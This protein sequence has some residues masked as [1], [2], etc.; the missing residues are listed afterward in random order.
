[1]TP[2]PVYDAMVDQMDINDNDWVIEVAEGVIITTY[3]LN[4]GTVIATLPGFRGSSINNNNEVVGW[5]DDIRQPGYWSNGTLTTLAAPSE[6]RVF[7]INDSGTIIGGRFNSGVIWMH[8]QMQYLDS[9]V[10]PIYKI[11]G[12]YAI[13]NKGEILCHGYLSQV[14][15]TCL[16][17][18]TTGEIVAPKASAIWIA[19]ENDTIRWDRIN[20]G[21]SL[22]I[23]Y[24][25]NSGSNWQMIA[26]AVSAGDKKYVWDI[27]K[28][29][30]STKCFIRLRDFSTLDTLAV[31]EMFKIK[32][33]TITKLDINGDYIRYDSSKDVWGFANTTADIYPMSWYSRFNYR[34]IDPF[35]GSTYS[36]LQGD[37]VFQYAVPAD[38]PDWISFVNTF[39]PD[40]CYWNR[41]LGIYSQR[42][43]EKWAGLKH[44]WGGSCFGIAISNALGFERK[45]EFRN[46]YTHF[47]DFT[48]AITIVSDTNVIPAINEL[49]SH[50][51]GNPHVTIRNNVGLLKTPTQTINDLKK[52]FKDDL[53]I[54]TLSIL[55]NGEGG[56]GHAI[57]AYKMDRVSYVSPVWNVHVYDNSYPN[58]P[59][60]IIEVDTSQK[61]GNGSWAPQ[62]GW[63]TWGG[64]KWFYLRDPAMD[65]LS[66]P[67]LPK[68]SV[69]NSPFALNENVLE[70]NN[71]VEA[72]ITIKD[73]QGR[74]TGFVNNYIVNQIPGSSP[75]V[76]ENGSVGAPYGYMMPADNYSITLDSF[77]TT[78]SRAVFF[79]GNTTLGYERSDAELFQTDNLHFDTTNSPTLSAANPDLQIKSVSLQNILNET[80]EEKVYLIHS[81]ELSEN[82][83]VAIRNVDTDRLKLVSYGSAKDYDLNIEHASTTRL[84]VFGKTNIPLTSNTTHTIEPN[85][86]DLDSSLLTVLV[87]VGNDGTI[88]DTL[89]LQNELTGVHDHGSLIPSEYKLYQNYPN[90]FNPTTTIQFDIPKTSFV[91]LKVYNVLGQEVATLVNEKREAGRYEVKFNASTLSN[92]VYFYR[93]A[94][95]DYSST[96]KFVLIK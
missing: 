64:D 65:Y 89:K 10:P 50:Q 14:L 79:T 3:V 69:R 29:V 68:I 39:T 88:D 2:Y 92:G 12:A 57:L 11:T 20:S 16:L 9:L 38:F 91:T 70:V 72:S 35:T 27:P 37:H 53:P 67:S 75:L 94:A 7:A 15:G 54:Q 28:E 82:D 62:Y 6:T 5:R 45:D 85:W 58:V 63:L 81:L 86:V 49:Y 42:A 93:L 48:T 87:D 26:S 47:P 51:Y 30:L 44:I 96:K 23:E 31:S 56:G 8:G 22:I 41:T 25:T 4:G 33:Y 80:T 90:P 66:N 13:N 34:G 52:M 74:T 32:P 84:Q 77:K 59:D 46:K 55:N 83:S 60:A 95:G 1:M 61:G 71:T 73:A 18:P 17:T 21:V 40:A 19:G 78:E 36:Q 24:S 43:L 76:I